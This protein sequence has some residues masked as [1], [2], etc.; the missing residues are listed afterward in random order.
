MVHKVL[1]KMEDWHAFPLKIH[2]GENGHYVWDVFSVLVI[3][4][5]CL[6][7]F[8]TSEVR[9]WKCYFMDPLLYS[10]IQILELRWEEC[11]AVIK[12]LDPMSRSSKGMRQT[13]GKWTWNLNHLMY[14]STVFLDV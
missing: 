7:E 5:K 6:L 2:D 4:L 14:F 8:K 10:V 9:A 13:H 3:G 1:L 11:G 12:G